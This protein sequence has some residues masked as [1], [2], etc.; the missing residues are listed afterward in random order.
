MT[1]RSCSPLLVLV[2]MML[3][4]TPAR[5]Q[6]D[7]DHFQT[8]P[9]NFSNPGA[10]STAMGGAFIGLA[11][12]AS[13]AVA[14]PAG[15]TSL[16]RK[17]IYLE[18]KT[19][20]APVVILPAFNSLAGGIGSLTGQI[21]NMPS[22]INFAMPVNDKITI[23][24]SEHEF[25]SYKNSF[26][27]GGTADPQGGF[28]RRTIGVSSSVFPATNTI[29]NMSGFS[30]SGAVGMKVNPK[31]RVGASASIN[32]LSISAD[33]HRNVL[34]CGTCAKVPST[35]IHDSPV[36]AGFTA[37]MLYQAND[38]LSI[39]LIYAFEPRFKATE[40]V[41]PENGVAGYPAP[42]QSDT[43]WPVHF[44]TP[45]RVGAGVGYRA[46]ERILVA[47]DVVWVQYSTLG[48]FDSNQLVLFRHYDAL[49]PSSGSN[50]PPL[51]A[52]VDPKQFHIDNNVDFHTGVEWNVIRGSNPV[53]VRWGEF[54][55]APHTLRFGN[56]DA[57]GTS[58]SDPKFGTGCSLIDQFF[59]VSQSA[60]AALPTK[61]P[62]DPTLS[63]SDFIQ[64]AK[65]ESGFSVG[66]G[67]VV[68]T[69]ST[70]VQIDAAYLHTNYKRSEFV[71]S[72][73]IRF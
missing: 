49:Y 53:F 20:N 18:Y 63:A 40:T 48:S 39:G 2:A 6:T 13:A 3:T 19:L 32:R 70:P 10:R 50:I 62:N 17:Q 28:G 11:D 60:H 64:V 33:A 23:A 71:L 47:G 38:N 15:L 1:F 67:I 46:S 37:G 34:P 30:Y 29:I 73:A 54:F 25:L 27:L 68:G 22:F 4:A 65:R 52:E 26:L 57:C 69:R 8:F 41:I 43:S 55:T 5:A 12:D 7:E 45:P 21:R 42:F 36:A 14:N 58:L 31:L 51:G 24:V 35:A 72:S 66:A 16:G 59:F 44:N 56:A 61:D 9:F